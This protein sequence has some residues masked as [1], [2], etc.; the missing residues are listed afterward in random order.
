MKTSIKKALACTFASAMAL[1]CVAVSAVSGADAN[2]TLDN[3]AFGSTAVGGGQD[4]VIVDPTGNTNRSYALYQIFNGNL[5]TKGNLIDISWGESIVN[6]TA[7]DYSTALVEELKAE[8]FS[9]GEANPI[10]S[11]FSDVTAED[12]VYSAEKI[13]G[14]VAKID[15]DNS[16][17]LDAFATAVAYVIGD[18][19]VSK[20][21]ITGAS[22]PDGD[23]G[24]EYLFSD[25][26]DGYYMAA[27]ITS[28]KTITKS[29]YMLDVGTSSTGLEIVAKASG[30]PSLDKYIKYGADIESTKDVDESLHEYEEVAIND[31]VTFQLSSEVP[32]MTGYSKYY[33]VINDTLSKG[34]DYQAIQSITVG[35]QTLT[36]YDSSTNALTDPTYEIETVDNDD[37]TTGITIVFKNFIQYEKEDTITVLYTATVNED[38]VVGETNANTNTANLTYSNDPNY[39]YTGTPGSDDSENPQD[40]DPD[41]PNPGEPTSDTPDETVYVYTTGIELL[42]TDGNGK[43][44]AGATFE[45]SGTTL[46]GEQVMKFMRVTPSYTAVCYDT[47]KE[48]NFKSDEAAYYKKKTNTFT[49]DAYTTDGDNPTV[50]RYVSE[51]KKYTK[52]GDTYTED[53]NGT[54]YKDANSDTYYEIES[55]PTDV[56]YEQGY[57]L[58][59]LSEDM[60]VMDITPASTT[61]TDATSESDAAGTVSADSNA[62]SG[63]VSADNGTVSFYGLKAGS[64]TIKETEAPFG[65]V[66]LTAPI[67][68][69]IT[70]TEPAGS[71]VDHICNWEYTVT[72]NGTSGN[73]VSS[74]ELSIK[75]NILAIQVKNL[76]TH[77]LPS[78]GGI[79]TT[80]FYVVGSLLAAAAVVLLITKRRMHS[81]NE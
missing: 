49:I 41:K 76:T 2:V 73:L 75:N 20:R 11:L 64:Y 18:K 25:V 81:E 69:E 58:Y 23:K 63:T 34:M 62:V 57:V 66:A 21:T 27:E 65:Y 15:A 45:I 4:I 72:N 40:P 13:A 17:A 26:K 37:G 9:N 50:S 71:S 46:D 8:T 42:K 39:A 70:Y 56:T 60:T 6:G 19:N 52:D 59:K 5:D 74:A 67:Q 22:D 55:A 53:I 77:T 32:D 61:T 36:K 29:R 1:S 44:L 48:S 78:T 43:A 16:E 30:S 31:T 38:I 54:Y 68:V 35:D 47:Q 80:I 3:K 7:Y 14:I 51:N 28:D 33:F 12:G 24:P 10:A 79:G